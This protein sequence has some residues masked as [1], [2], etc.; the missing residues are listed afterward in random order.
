MQKIARV[1]ALIFPKCNGCMN[2]RTNGRTDGW[3]EV[4][5]DIEYT[6]KEFGK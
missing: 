4:H 6:D 5:T 1:L 3:M 2:G